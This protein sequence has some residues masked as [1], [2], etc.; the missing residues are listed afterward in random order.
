MGDV[1]ACVVLAHESCVCLR[2]VCMDGACTLVRMAAACASLV[3]VHG[4]MR[5]TV[6][7]HGCMRG[8]C[9]WMLHV[10]WCCLCM[11]VACA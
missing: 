6:A 2:G 1:C 11:C 7:A 9:V 5:I 10:H 4:C 8:A 3:Y